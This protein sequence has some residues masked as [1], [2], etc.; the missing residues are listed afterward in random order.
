MIQTIQYLEKQQQKLCELLIKKDEEIEQ[1]I[2]EHGGIKRGIV[3]IFF[4]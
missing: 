1:H 3:M 4:L 2:F